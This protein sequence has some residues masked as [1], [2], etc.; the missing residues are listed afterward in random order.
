[1]LRF[2]IDAVSDQ[3]LRDLQDIEARSGEAQ[4]SGNGLK[5]LGYVRGGG[6]TVGEKWSAQSFVGKSLSFKHPFDERV[7]VPPEQ[8]RVLFV[9]ATSSPNATMARREE[10]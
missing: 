10:V 6:V 9:T 1:M 7:R 5:I 2:D 8:A 3:E 4:V